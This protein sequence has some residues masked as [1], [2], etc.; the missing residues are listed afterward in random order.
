MITLRPEAVLAPVGIEHSVTNSGRTDRTRGSAHRNIRLALPADFNLPVLNPKMVIPVHQAGCRVQLRRILG[1]MRLLNNELSRRDSIDPVEIKQQK[2]KLL[3]CFWNHLDQYLSI[4]TPLQDPIRTLATPQC[5]ALRVL[6]EHLR[7]YSKW[8]DTTHVEIQC[9]QVVERFLGSIQNTEHAGYPSSDG[10][11]FGAY[12]NE[13]YSLRARNIIAT[14]DAKLFDR[15]GPM[16]KLVKAISSTLR[17]EIEHLGQVTIVCEID[18]PSQPVNYSQTARPAYGVA[19]DTRLKFLDRMMEIQA[20]RMVMNAN[21]NGFLTPFSRMELEESL[22][23]ENVVLHA[24]FCDGVM[25]GFSLL[26]KGRCQSSPDENEAMHQLSTTMNRYLSVGYIKALLVVKANDRV[27]NLPINSHTKGKEG[28]I[29][30]NA[31][32]DFGVANGYA[33]FGAW[34]RVGNRS[35][36]FL[37]SHGFERIGKVFGIRDGDT[38]LECAPIK[39]DI[40]RSNEKRFKVKRK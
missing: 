17:Q 16:A 29:I 2:V 30:L 14:G 6:A 18:H 36:T 11:L 3:D 7:S 26:K 40:H 35:M 21:E 32:A 10:P 34:C 38:D 23:D 8:I 1:H 31:I 37:L 20:S 15:D 19:T 25:T 22:R 5:R 33:S 13:V 4:K 27:Q 12:C 28:P 9:A 24:T 39:F